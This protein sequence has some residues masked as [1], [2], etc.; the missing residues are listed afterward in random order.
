[1]KRQVIRGQGRLERC[2]DKNLA[3]RTDLEYRAAA[4]PDVQIFRM[5]ERDARRDA[6]TLNPLLGAAFRRDSMNGAVMAARDK[7][8][9]G[10]VHGQARWINQRSDKRLDAVI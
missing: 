5:V 7:Q 1:M 10:P 4:I 8:I 2:E 3:A 6:H 9:A